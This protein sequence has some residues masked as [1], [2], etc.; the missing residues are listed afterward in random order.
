MRQT[1]RHLELS[2]RIKKSLKAGS[3]CDGAS[4][5]T[6]VVDDNLNSITEALSWSMQVSKREG[7][8]TLILSEIR[9]EGAKTAGGGTASGPCSFARVFDSAAAAMLRPGKKNGVLVMFL[10]ADHPDLDKW[11]DLKPELQRGYLG[12]LLRPSTKLKK[13]LVEKIAKAYDTRRV[14]FI[15]KVT[16][17]KD[18]EPLYPNVCTEIRQKHKGS[19]T[20]AAIR[21]YELANKPL[22]EWVGTGRDIGRY[23]HEFIIPIVKG[24]S[25]VSPL[26]EWED[27]VGIGLVGFANLLA[28]EGVTYQEFVSAYTSAIKPGI[29]DLGIVEWVCTAVGAIDEGDKVVQLWI[30]LISLWVAIACEMPGTNRI[31]TQQPTAATALRC[32]DD[33]W[34]VAPEI[35]PPYACRSS[36]DQISRAI[37][38]SEL[39]GGAVIQYH[40]SVQ[41]RDEVGNDVYFALCCAFQEIWDLLGKG[42]T[43][44][45]SSWRD[46][47]TADTIIEFIRSPLGSMYYRLD[48]T[49]ASTFNKSETWDDAG[50]L[51]DLFPDVTAEEEVGGFCPINPADRGSCES[52]SM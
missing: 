31:F 37:L 47:Y 44:S 29:N 24:K 19:C 32:K 38:Q 35:A 3:T 22:A 36:D 7:A 45:Y 1:P 13:G 28:H 50:D 25:I 27:Q 46:Q 11:L 23:F 4:C 33:G 48:P 2:S 41:V 5:N 21:V 10:D 34:S 6:F 14:D 51:G 39:N 26:Y 43:L 8:P 9:P 15:C 12:V 40:P 18:G 52:C 16:E 49:P 17:D 20:L 30:R 42:H